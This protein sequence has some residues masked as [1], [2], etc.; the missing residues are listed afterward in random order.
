MKRK[1]LLDHLRATHFES[2]D[3]D[4]ALADAR[5]IA[6]FLRS[7][8]ARRVWGIGSA[9][10]AGRPFTDRSDIDLVAEGIDPREFY[11]LSAEAAAITEF[12]LDLTPLESATPA[13]KRI[14]N[15]KGVVL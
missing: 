11:A 14:T 8:G 3:R 12:S 4:L 7:N 5:Q 15:E 9:F 13:L 2:G 1:A 6:G 10:D